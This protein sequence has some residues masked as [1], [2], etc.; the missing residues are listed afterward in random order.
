MAYIFLLPQKD[1]VVGTLEEN[2]TVFLLVNNKINLDLKR[3]RLNAGDGLAIGSSQAEFHVNL[4][5]GRLLG[6]PE[7]KVE[8]S[9]ISSG[10]GALEL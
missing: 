5:M 10:N 4:N 7:P 2:S 3:A 1:K 6:D 9:V 8:L